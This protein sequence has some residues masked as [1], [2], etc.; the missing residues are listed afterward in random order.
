MAI[1]PEKIIS[2]FSALVEDSEHKKDIRRIFDYDNLEKSKIVWWKGDRRSYFENT[3]SACGC[4]FYKIVDGRIKLLLYN[5]LD[6][7]DAPLDDFGGKVDLYD[8]NVY[9]TMR[10]EVLEETNN[11]IDIFYINSERFKEYFY[12]KFSKYYTALIEVDEDFFP[13]T[14]IFGTKECLEGI[15]RVIKWY[16]YLDSKPRLSLRIR[17]NKFLIDHL[18]NLIF[19]IGFKTSKYTKYESREVN[20]YKYFNKKKRPR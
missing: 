9:E 16:D 6:S 14:S 18:D 7:K 8:R 20:S 11:L 17:E 2:Q 10:R 15:D 3:I 12:V 4:L 13:D 1:D 5:Y 19:S